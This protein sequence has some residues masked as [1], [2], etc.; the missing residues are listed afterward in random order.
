MGGGYGGGGM[1]GLGA[2]DV[3]VG[4]APHPQWGGGG[5]APDPGARWRDGRGAARS[6][7]WAC[8]FHP[9]VLRE[10]LER[11]RGKGACR[12]PRWDAVLSSGLVAGAT[13]GGSESLEHL[14]RIFVERSHPLWRPDG[15]QAF[16][17][18][19]AEEAVAAAGAE[20]GAVEGISVADWAAVRGEVFPEGGGNQFAHL[21]LE[22]FAE[23]QAVLPADEGAPAA[24][25]GPAAAG[26]AGGGGGV[27][28]GLAGAL[29]AL[30]PWYQGPQGAP[31]EDD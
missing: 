28:G 7:A 25:P 21:D 17:L 11:L 29:Q 20:G 30:M 24:D 5:G 8:A 10:L 22:Q 6:A 16:L 9:A 2:Y 13:F 18:A 27:A 26:A 31:Q 3:G 12:G 14:S 15:P 1:A 19:A 23:A 4:G